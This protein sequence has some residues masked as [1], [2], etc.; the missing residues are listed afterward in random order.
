MEL[1]KSFGELKA[2][3]LVKDSSTGTSKGF[4]FFEYVDPSVTD[5]ATQGLNGME[6][7][8]RFLVVQRASVG[9]KQVT[10][11]PGM[12]TAEEYQT[13]LT[14]RRTVIPRALD[15]TET[16]SRILLMLNM[17]TND[18]LTNDEDYNDILEDVREECG[19]YGPVEDLRIPR[20][21]KR[22]KKWSVDGAALQ[23]QADEDSG[24]GR[25]YV[26][27]VDADSAGKALA[28]LA[29]RAFAGRSIVAT[30]LAD[31]ADTSPP[32][33]IIFA[34]P[35]GEDPPPPPPTDAPPVPP[36]AYMF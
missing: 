8:D 1:L 15:L 22:D 19:N 11:I 17:V 36:D 20:P 34:P 27:F 10:G 13:A 5:I 4:A 12:P 9:A 32:L 26:K 30:L 21:A 35:G 14:G 2:F 6:L 23:R 3:N 31:D 25:V 18:D 28:S 24:V 16:T 29:G 7:G 33:D